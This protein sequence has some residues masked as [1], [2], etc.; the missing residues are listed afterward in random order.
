MPDPLLIIGDILL[1]TGLV[2]SGSIFM[3]I[4]ILLP[5]VIIALLGLLVSP[6]VAISSYLNHRNSSGSAVSIA[7]RDFLRSLCM[8]LPFILSDGNDSVKS[9]HRGCLTASYVYTHL[10]WFVGCGFA[11]TFI[12]LAL[13]QHFGF[14]PLSP[15]TNTI[16]RTVAIV[17]IVVMVPCIYSA[18]VLW[19]SNDLKRKIALLKDEDYRDSISIAPFALTTVWIWITLIYSFLAIETFQAAG[20][21]FWDEDDF[22]SLTTD[23]HVTDTFYGIVDMIIIVLAFIVALQIIGI[24]VWI[25]RSLTDLVRLELAHR[26]VAREVGITGAQHRPMPRSTP[27]D[28]ESGDS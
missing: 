6:F 13:L 27:P 15:A 4:I 11:G 21:E 20:S 2:N 18:A 24:G 7:A 19:R 28:A 14:D 10:T 1:A 16:K 23:L 9:S 12:L 3:G 25:V 8:L 22:S 26:R 17:A 5:S